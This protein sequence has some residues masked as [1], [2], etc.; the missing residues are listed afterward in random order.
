M[1]LLWWKI[2]LTCLEND[3]Y[4]TPELNEKLYLH[5]RG[6]RR[7]EN[8]DEY[9]ACKALWLDSNGIDTI[10][11]LEPLQELRCL[12]LGKNLVNKVS[13]LDSL[14]QLTTIDLSYNRITHVTGLSCC[15]NLSSVNL[16]RNALSTAESISHLLECQA[17]VSL[18]LT[19][20]RL[21][22]EDTLEVIA[23]IPKLAN[24]SV[25]GNE[26]AKLP[27]FRKRLIHKAGRK[28]GY[29]DRPVDE[30]EHIAAAA[31]H[32]GG[33][34]A[35]R[36]AKED[37]REEQKRKRA[38]ETVVF[39]LWQQEQ[40]EKRKAELAAGK[41]L[42]KELTPEEL[43]QREV[44]AEA[45]AQAEKRMLDAG[46]ENVARKFH[47]LDTGGGDVDSMLEAAVGAVEADKDLP[48]TAE[49]Y[50]ARRAAEE[51]EIRVAE[52]KN[53]NPNPALREP[54]S[55]PEVEEVAPPSPP[56]AE[57]QAAAAAAAAEVEAARLAAEESKQQE[58]EHQAL[59]DESMAIYN[60]LRKGG[61]DAVAR[62]PQPTRSTWASGG[63]SAIPA[64]DRPLYWSEAM[65]IE[66]AR[67]VKACVF[68]F[69]TIAAELQ[70]QCAG[71]HFGLES[72][73]LSPRLTSEECRLHWAKL[74]ASQWCEEAPDS[75]ALNTNFKVN[76]QPITL[77]GG[78]QPSFDDIARLA[79]G[80][81]PKYLQVPTAFPSVADEA[82]SDEDD[83]NVA[84]LDTTRT[85]LP[86]I[87]GDDDDLD[88]MD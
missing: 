72:M 88:A 37:W 78:V 32:E 39:R 2:R 24:L 22:G 30:L 3:G 83:E 38:Q 5:F 59:V 27:S 4:D 69:D 70:K 51:E 64:V 84:P 6:F 23:H 10:E 43:A 41:S 50:E 57:E 14:K 48:P 35:E 44:E 15:P 1:W 63:A 53:S 85:R 86:I 77:P 76:V 11:N 33:I 60:Q 29:I 61:A 31:F 34:E 7:I 74:D 68:D 58:A 36:K 42:Y 62:N 49:E 71:G 25:N 52:A 80:S 21:G 55:E 40:K 13:G 18:D 65:D 17:L 8:L 82:S 87:T 46:I 79:K 75:S 47:Q 19:N 20:N 9:T 66:L 28:L 16:G 81:M 56:S 54:E 45:A 67:Q 12:Y 26:L 73:S